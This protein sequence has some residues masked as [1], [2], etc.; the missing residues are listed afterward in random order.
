[1]TIYD[2]VLIEVDEEYAEYVSWE[3]ERIME[4]V[5]TDKETGESWCRVPITATAKVMGRWEK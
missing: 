3:V 5:L 1:M 4:G 2:E